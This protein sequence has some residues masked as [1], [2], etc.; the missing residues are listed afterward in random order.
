MHLFEALT[1]LFAG[2]LTLAL[3]VVGGRIPRGTNLLPVACLAP[4]GLHLLFEGA[5]W[6]MVPVYLVVIALL[7]FGVLRYWRLPVERGGQILAR[8]LGISGFLLLM[9]SVGAGIAFAR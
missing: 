6:R 3:A 2:Q 4:L 7:L 5:R 1:I 9:A 8:I